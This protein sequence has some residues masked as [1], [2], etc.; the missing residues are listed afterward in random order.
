MNLVVSYFAQLTY[1]LLTKDGVF[2]SLYKLMD[3]S[4][5]GEL[6]KRDSSV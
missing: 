1:V 3:L 4:G 2:S 6:I 5:L